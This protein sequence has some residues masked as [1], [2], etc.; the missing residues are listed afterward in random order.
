[1]TPRSLTCWWPVTRAFVAATPTCRASSSDL[2]LTEKL[3]YVFQTD[4]LDIQEVEQ[5]TYSINQYLF[6]SINDCLKLGGRIEWWKAD[7]LITGLGNVSVYEATAGVNI[8]PH[9]N[10]RVRPEIRQQWAPGVDY[11]ETIFGIDVIATF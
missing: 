3:N 1:M 7:P 11:D 2:N 10:F 5:N 8:I 4:W 9:A 6:Y